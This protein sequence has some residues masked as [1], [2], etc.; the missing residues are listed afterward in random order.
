[1]LF[2]FKSVTPLTKI[3]YK[4]VKEKIVPWKIEQS[5][6]YMNNNGDSRK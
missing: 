3:A 1:M 5:N 2:F 6:Y 4:L